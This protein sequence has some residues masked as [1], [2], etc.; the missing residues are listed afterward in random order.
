MIT[1]IKAH[2]QGDFTSA[3]PLNPLDLPPQTR[4]LT[5]DLISMPP[6]SLL[7]HAQLA[8]PHYKLADGRCLAAGLAYRVG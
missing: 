1:E 7:D 6:V 4:L 3:F 2:K 8:G 5:Y